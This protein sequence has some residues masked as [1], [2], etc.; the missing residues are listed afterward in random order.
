MRR[1]RCLYR[2]SGESKSLISGIVT[3]TAELR[4]IGVGAVM[5]P[6]AQ[7]GCCPW[8]KQSTVAHPEKLQEVQKLFRVLR[9]VG[10]A[11]LVGPW[12]WRGL[13]FL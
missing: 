4:K 9:T 11:E 3:K 6:S 13:S 1:L 10:S 8:K 5:G 7:G 12:N 2:P